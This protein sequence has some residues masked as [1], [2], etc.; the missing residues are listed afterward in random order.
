MRI[1]NS[2]HWSDVIEVVPTASGPLD[3]TFTA[4]EP[5]KKPE[6]FKFV[7]DHRSAL[8]CDLQRF[9]TG[10]E[11]DDTARRFTAVKITRASVR[12]ECALEV[13]DLAVLGA[14]LHTAAD[15]GALQ[16]PP[17]P[18]GARTGTPKPCPL[19]HAEAW[20]EALPPPLTTPS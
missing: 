11:R 4:R 12:A 19:G 5:G 16:A 6:V 15:S 10:G 7:A 20:V 9:S 18:L 17:Y 14:T 8:L 3:F 13:G 1:T 2:W